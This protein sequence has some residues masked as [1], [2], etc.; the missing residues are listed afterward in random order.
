MQNDF[1]NAYND[2]LNEL[3]QQLNDL[4]ATTATQSE[5]IRQLTTVNQSLRMQNEQLQ[6]LIDKLTTQNAKLNNEN[7][8]LMS[9]LQ[10]NKKP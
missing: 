9:L 1:T 8:R 5:Q 2:L 3:E 4:Q 7:N 6:G 10:N